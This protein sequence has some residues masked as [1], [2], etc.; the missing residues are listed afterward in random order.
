MSIGTGPEVWSAAVVAGLSADLF[1]HPMETII[2]RVQSPLYTIR[3]KSNGRIKQNLF[4]GLY[5]G[6][7]PTLLTGI[8]SS[9]AFFIIYEGMKSAFQES[10]Y[11][12]AP[13]WAVHV[14]SSGVAELVNCA[15]SNPAE[16]LKQNAQIQLGGP[17]KPWGWYTVQAIRHFSA[18]PARL[19][20]GYSALLASH[21]PGTCLTFGIYEHIKAQILEKMGETDP[22]LAAS[23]SMQVQ[24]STLSAGLAGGF[25]S[26][27]LVP[28]DVIKTRMRLAAGGHG[29]ETLERSRR[30]SVSFLNIA[31]ETLHTEGMPGLFRGFTL[32]CVAA[33]IGSG[34]YLGCYEG[35]K[36]Y[37]KDMGEVGD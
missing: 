2:T 19:W 34:L 32:T 28:I 9:A 26:C 35:V 4:R 33:T 22:Q 14:A 11:L 5:Q 37:I 27:F 36:L 24:V 16:V 20:T 17:R 29:V 6:F 31:K 8:P 30:P 21:L 23:T 15:I 12:N 10:G 13:P 7:G 25:T 1:V 18:H 3:Y